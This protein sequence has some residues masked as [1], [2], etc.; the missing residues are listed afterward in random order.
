[1][2]DD[3]FRFYVA[4]FEGLGLAPAAADAVAAGLLDADLSATDTHGIHRLPIYAERIRTGGIAVDAEVDVVRD[5]GS[6][7]LL[8]G[9]HGPGQVAATK[10]MQLAIE[11]AE[12][13]G[14]AAV[15]VRRSN[16]LGTLAYY[17]KM[18]L[19]HSQIGFAVTG[20]AS[21]IA[22]WG[23]SEAL[24]GSNPWSWA[25]PARRHPPIVV[26]Q[27]NGIVTSTVTRNPDSGDAIPEGVAI[28]SEGR[29]A[30]TKRAALGGSLLPIGGH[31]GYGLTLV[32]EVLASVLPGAAYSY[33]VAKFDEP[34][35]PKSIGHFMMAID[36]ARF[37]AVQ[38]FT[39]R[40]DDL[41]DHLLAAHHGE[42]QPGA[43]IPG[44]H[45]AASEVERRARGVPISAG[46]LER[47]LAVAESLG[48]PPLKTSGGE[49][50]P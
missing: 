23:A 13:H 39:D 10:A 41:L 28:D 45:S 48:V 38:S 11:R 35:R 22:P 5:D 49:R 15:A 14:I 32:L 24:L 9:N 26:D 1:M 31:K 46:N 21:S 3:L 37:D 47:A 6:T 17:S 19:S 7:V 29:P 34:G 30:T 2:P 44:E 20:V 16:H 12:R 4:C 27:A 18:A 40:I 25:I 33:Q 43:R 50:L 42:E 8:D 36:I